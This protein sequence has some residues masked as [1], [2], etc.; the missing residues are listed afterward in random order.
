M[1]TKLIDLCLQYRPVVLL[2]AVILI[3]LGVASFRELPFDAFPDTTPVQVQVN[4]TAPAL[5]PVEIERQI[6]FEVE[7]SIAGLPGLVEVRSVSKFGFSQVVAIFDDETD[8]YLARQNVS[9]RVV[10]VNLPPGVDTPTLGPVATGLGEVFQYI[11]ESENLS[12]QELRT[13]H[14]WV[15]RPQMVQTPGVAE[16]NTWGGYEKQFHVLLDPK[17]LI[18]HE[19]TLDDV[20]RALRQGNRNVGGGVID[21]AGESFIPKAG[22]PLIVRLGGNATGS[23]VYRKVL[24]QFR[25]IELRGGA[26]AQKAYARQHQQGLAIQK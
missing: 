2:G 12:P 15:I 23:K 1:L 22:P 17:L 7:Q 11:V 24:C 10:G 16:I 14:H 25:A 21:Q 3:V 9:E 5:S 6:T 13:L 20:A 4:T 8:I 18:K 26:S 19:L